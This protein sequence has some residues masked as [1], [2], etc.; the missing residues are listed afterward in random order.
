[1]TGLDHRCDLRTRYTTVPTTRMMHG[2]NTS[3]TQNTPRSCPRVRTS[4]CPF[5]RRSD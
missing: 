3:D 1:M 5:S 2:T 4:G